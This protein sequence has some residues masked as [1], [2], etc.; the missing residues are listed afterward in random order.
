[1]FV[2]SDNVFG[3]YNGSRNDMRNPK[4]EFEGHIVSTK[5]HLSTITPV[6]DEE[7]L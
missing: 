7:P 4:L 5:S 1:M 3:D 2:V 6:I